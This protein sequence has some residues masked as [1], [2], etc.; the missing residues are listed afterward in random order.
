MCIRDSGYTKRLATMINTSADPTGS[1]QARWQDT[2]AAIGYVRE[3]PLI[4]AGIGQDILALNEARGLGWRSVHNVYLQYAVDLGLPGAILF[5]VLLGLCVSAA[6]AVERS[7][8]GE[9]LPALAAALRISLC[10]L[11]T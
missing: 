8:L 5:V 1:A 10:L 2:V 9:G 7:D 6:A 4:G 3:N 11:Y